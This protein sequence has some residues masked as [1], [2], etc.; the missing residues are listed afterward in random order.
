MNG[1][2]PPFFGVFNLKLKQEIKFKFQMNVAMVEVVLKKELLVTLI[3]K[4]HV[5][6]CCDFFFLLLVFLIPT[7]L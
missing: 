1:L 2:T 3:Y 7:D 5:F 4:I 6:I